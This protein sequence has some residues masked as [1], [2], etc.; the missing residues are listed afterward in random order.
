MTAAEIISK[1]RTLKKVP[2]CYMDSRFIQAFAKEWDTQDIHDVLEACN[3]IGN[4]EL[5]PVLLN[6]LKERQQS[7]STK[8]I[9]DSIEQT[10]NGNYENIFYNSSIK[11]DGFS[12][13]YLILN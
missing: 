12:T 3:A 6:I 8:Q 10:S 11:I 9:W 13:N 7:S 4:E 5:I 1:I 2:A